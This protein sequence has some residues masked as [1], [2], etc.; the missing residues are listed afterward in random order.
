MT[1]EERRLYLIQRL[2]MEMPQYQKVKIPVNEDGQKRLMRSLMNVRP[3]LPAS[4]KFLKVQDAY[5]MEEARRRGIVDGQSLTPVQPGSR[6]FLWKGDITCLKT[7]AIVNAANSA[8]LG[9][10]QPCHSCIDN[11]IHTFSGIQ[12]RLACDEIMRRQGHAE[13]TGTAKITPAFNLPCKYVLHTVG[14]VISGPVKEEDRRLLAGCYRSCLELCVQNHVASV[15]FCCI[16]T[17]VFCFPQDEAAQIAVDTVTSFLEQ[18]SS[19]R[20]VIFDVFADEDYDIY[21]RLLAK[22]NSYC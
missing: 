22:K 21:K 9:C 15:A 2:L 4:D 18:D 16:S 19:I 6:I 10:F 1:Q 14:P 12:L 17:G 20:Q 5:L 3:P 7:D 8:L 11:S 13:M